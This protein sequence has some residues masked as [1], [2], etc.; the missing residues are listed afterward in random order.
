[1]IGLCIVANVGET[2]S[3]SQRDTF[4]STTGNPLSY[5]EITR[6]KFKLAYES[7]KSSLDSIFYG[8]TTYQEQQTIN[9]D[10]EEL[11]EKAKK[12]GIE[13]VFSPTQVNIQKGRPKKQARNP[14]KLEIIKEE[15]RKHDKASMDANRKRKS[16]GFS[17]DND[18][19]IP[20]VKKPKLQ[21]QPLEKT[22]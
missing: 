19:H 14:V 2:T 16:A 10:L 15:L 8:A 5:Q 7:L 3:S 13:S 6:K 11:L 21:A 4:E 17:D 18:P 22:G 20:D 12:N 1:M 9:D